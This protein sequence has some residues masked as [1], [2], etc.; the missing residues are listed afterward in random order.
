MQL[1]TVEIV[2]RSQIELFH[3]NKAGGG[4]WREGLCFSAQRCL[5][6]RAKSLALWAEQIRAPHSDVQRGFA[7]QS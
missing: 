5:P 2:Y 7:Q 1:K 4:A 6:S 3:S